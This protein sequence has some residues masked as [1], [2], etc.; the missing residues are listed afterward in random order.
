M[1][2]IPSGIQVEGI[3]H[4]KQLIEAYRKDPLVHNNI[5][6][7]LGLDIFDCKTRIL[8][9]LRNL[10]I[11]VLITH[12]QADP[13]VKCSGSRKIYECIG[14]KEKE[15]FI[16]SNLF[17]ETHNEIAIERKLPLK[18]LQRWFDKYQ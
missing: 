7:S 10:K 14:S 11:P 9:K 17:H 6:L 5:S 18:N 3:S 4:D 1:L 15:I 16:Y 12:G 13:I 2:I 8:S